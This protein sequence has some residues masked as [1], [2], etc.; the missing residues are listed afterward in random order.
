MTSVTRDFTATTFVVHNERTLLLW[1]KKLNLWLPPGGHI[2]PN[3][4]PDEAA[5]REV[6]EETGLDVQL[7][8][9]QK[10]MENVVF[11][12][13]PIAILLENISPVHQHVDLIYFAFVKG[14]T[15][16]LN[17]QEAVELKWFSKHDL[18]SSDIAEDIRHLGSL[19]INDV[20]IEPNN[21]NND[22]K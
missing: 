2:E 12:H 11:L 6:K 8:G 21:C 14:G 16:Q 5:I 7:M 22:E 18:Q 15:L 1:H 4:I 10:K 3:E 13:R 17:R 19:A 9:S 20:N